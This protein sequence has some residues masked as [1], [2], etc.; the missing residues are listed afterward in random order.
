M[1]GMKFFFE[2]NISRWLLSC[3]QYSSQDP[4]YWQSVNWAI[5]QFNAY[6][7]F[8]CILARILSFFK[9]LIYFTLSMQ[10][11]LHIKIGIL[12]KILFYL[13]INQHLLFNWWRCNFN[14]LC[15]KITSNPLR[16]CKLALVS[17]RHSFMVCISVTWKQPMFWTLL[18]KGKFLSCKEFLLNFFSMAVINFNFSS[19]IENETQTFLKTM[20]LLA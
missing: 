5:A 18:F 10:S 1:P 14:L 20:T 8:A 11:H 9:I 4:M 16:K 3:T 12:F 19:Y 7:G 15:S 2:P 13:N 17:N 6:I